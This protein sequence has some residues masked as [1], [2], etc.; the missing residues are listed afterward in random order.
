MATTSI[1][2]P[3]VIIE[4]VCESMGV[5]E[6]KAYHLLNR[7]VT[8]LFTA[9]NEGHNKSYW[10]PMDTHALFMLVENRAIPKEVARE[11]C[12]K[13][14]KY[15]RWLNAGWFTAGEVEI[16]ESLPEFMRFC[17]AT[18]TVS[19]FN[20]SLSDYIQEYDIHQC[21]LLLKILEIAGAHYS[22]LQKRSGCEITPTNQTESRLYAVVREV[23][24]GALEKASKQARDIPDKRLGF[25]ERRLREI[26]ASKDI[27]E[28]EHKKESSVFAEKPTGNTC[29]AKIPIVDGK[30]NVV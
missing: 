18:H 24:N 1:T 12:N 20:K 5:D 14:K 4:N 10:S 11:W 3:K 26:M 8:T 16:L 25:I 30:A 21:R 19:R 7:A 9:I 15:E 22:F 29:D 28:R 13:L 2:V 27:P 6:A 23:S 17:L